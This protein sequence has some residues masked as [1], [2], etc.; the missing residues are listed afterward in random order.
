MIRW[1]ISFGSILS[2]LTFYSQFRQF[3]LPSEQQNFQVTMNY[4]QVIDLCLYLDST[5]NE[6]DFD[7][8][9]FSANGS[10]VP[11][12][13]VRKAAG[14][15]KI[16]LLIMAA[17]HAGETDGIDAGFLFLR[18]ILHHQ[19][20]KK[21]LERFEI[22]FIPVF[23]VEGLQRFSSNQRIN[24]NGPSETGWR[25]NSL[26]LNLNRDFL[27]ADAPEMRAWLAWFHK[28][29]P[30]FV[31]D[32]HTTDGA[33]YQYTV[34]YS[35]G[36][37]LLFDDSLRI[38]L[39]E[40]LIPFLTEKMNETGDLLF[41]Y[42]IFKNWHDPTS[43]IVKDIASPNLSHGY[44]LMYDIPC[45]LIETHMLKPYKTRVEATERVLLY[46][47]IWLYENYQSFKKIMN[48][49][50][51]INTCER[52]KKAFPVLQ[53]AN[54]SDSMF[55]DFLGYSYEWIKSTVTNQQYVRYNDQHPKTFQLPYFGKIIASKEVNLPEAYLIPRQ[56]K[57]LIEILS[58]HDVY[59][60]PVR[61]NMRVSCRTIYL[62]KVRFSS[63]PYEGRFQPSYDVMEK[64]TVIEVQAGT[65]LVPLCQ[66][67]WRTIAY[68]LEPTSSVS[69]LKWGFFNA[70]FEQKEYG[71]IYV[72][73][74]LADEMIKNPQIQKEF[75]EWKKQNPSASHYEQLN[76]FFL[77]SKYADIYQNWYPVLKVYDKIEFNK[78]IPAR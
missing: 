74:P 34:T 57:H 61:N 50:H 28:T 51:R 64:D 11:L 73:E 69:F 41:P 24:Q 78:L 27:K 15:D 75:E 59:A 38:F 60:I 77:R 13:H 17:I 72:L 3:I 6:V 35:L 39:Q 46:I 18:S 20:L 53:Q 21:Y 12:L 2:W 36:N 49:V 23:N 45:F 63:M 33:N 67:G 5:Y 1:C 52:Y 58:Y 29:K 37:N 31:V 4:R 62:Q 8:L 43:G 22:F 16:K 76:C 54:M 56:Y 71:E 66:R 40:K 65:Y 25:T 30:D 70:I 44:T 19:M 10:I 14:E 7:T 26:N 48:K 68:L 42:I 55:I 9:G 47:Y 32:C